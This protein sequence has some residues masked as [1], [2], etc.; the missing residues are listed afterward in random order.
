M[1]KSWTWQ[2][3]LPVALGL[4]GRQSKSLITPKRARRRVSPKVSYLR[5][6]KQENMVAAHPAPHGRLPRW[7]RP[8]APGSRVP[9]ALAEAVGWRSER[10]G[11]TWRRPTVKP[12][13]PMWAAATA[14]AFGEAVGW[15]RGTICWNPTGM[16]VEGQFA[17]VEAM[18][19]VTNPAWGPPAAGPSQASLPSGSLQS[20]LSSGFPCI[21]HLPPYTE[22][23]LLDEF[24][25][26]Q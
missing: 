8:R 7:Q 25:Q 2:S 13:L 15:R 19:T 23:V 5:Y 3:P 24:S 9:R 16:A 1:E 14:D 22:I 20:C 18:C 6:N 10:V 11:A 26:A 17:G 4:P 12:R 21:L